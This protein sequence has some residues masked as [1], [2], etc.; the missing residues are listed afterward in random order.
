MDVPLALAALALV[1]SFSFV[2]G[3]PTPLTVSPLSSTLITNIQ[4]GNPSDQTPNLLTATINASSTALRPSPNFRAPSNQ[5]NTTSASP[6]V[7]IHYPV[8]GTPT[9]LLF[10][11]FGDPIPSSYMLQCLSLSLS[12]VLEFT[13]TDR[14]HEL[15]EHGFFFH[16][17][18][19]LNDDI[20]TIT[21]ADFREIGKPMDYFRLRDTLKG[22][23]DFVME[24]GRG[25][26]VLRFE[27]D[28][29][30]R[31]YVGTGHVGYERAREGG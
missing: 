25:P 21:V 30:G 23:G 12:I 10:H 15:I 11:A 29:E 18:L 16:K 4:T 27:V 6:Q 8:K 5:S 24:K 31:G 19:M 26:A 7:P 17:H 22:I 14:G 3:A 2:T 20:V 1:Q 9:T 28:V 13:L